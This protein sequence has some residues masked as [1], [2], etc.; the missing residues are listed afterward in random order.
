[1]MKKGMALACAAYGILAL[2]APVRAEDASCC[3]AA[4]GCGKS[5]CCPTTETKTVKKRYYTDRVEEFCLP[6]SMFGLL[7][8]K[9]ECCSKVMTRKDLIVKVRKQ[10][11]CCVKRCYP[12]VQPNSQTGCGSDCPPQC[13]GTAMPQA[14]AYGTTV[15]S[16]AAPMPSTPVPANGA[17]ITIS[18]VPNR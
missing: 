17:V 4:A 9:C 14:G 7:S 12:V 8:G 11:E 15:W 10:C 3:G 1:M 5:V 13:A 6:Y 2:V 16:R 18:S